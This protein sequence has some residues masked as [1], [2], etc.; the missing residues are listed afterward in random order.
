MGVR[1]REV[2]ASCYSRILVLY[3]PM[4]KDESSH[5]GATWAM[6]HSRRATIRAECMS[7]KVLP[8]RAVENWARA[9]SFVSFDR[10]SRL[11]VEKDPREKS[12]QHSNMV[13]V[14]VAMNISVTHIASSSCEHS[15][16]PPEIRICV[17]RAC[18]LDTEGS[19]IGFSIAPMFV[20]LA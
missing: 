5:P 12:T 17:H 14:Q 18:S 13:K 2:F 20:L 16:L 10:F 4:A 19:K 9:V 6:T 8:I 11:I 3:L 1:G 7:V 15:K